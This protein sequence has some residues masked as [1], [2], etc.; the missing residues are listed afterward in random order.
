[1]TEQPKIDIDALLPPRRRI[2]RDIVIILLISLICGPLLGLFVF[3]NVRGVTLKLSLG[4]GFAWGLSFVFVAAFIYTAW[5]I[6]HV[7]KG[8][9][10]RLAELK[11]EAYYRATEGEQ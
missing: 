4:T 3:G 8:Y 9:K 1:M 7:T 2:I 5:L 11:M 6:R 10:K